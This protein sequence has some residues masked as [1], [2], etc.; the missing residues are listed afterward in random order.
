MHT[1]FVKYARGQNLG[2]I[3]TDQISFVN[4][5]PVVAKCQPTK[6]MKMVPSVLNPNLAHPA[7][8]L[9]RT[10]GGVLGNYEFSS[11]YL[12]IYDPPTKSTKTPSRIQL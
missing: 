1:G 7:L 2:D 9:E 3:E 8:P 10:N 11:K 4:V 6:C 12:N 5:E